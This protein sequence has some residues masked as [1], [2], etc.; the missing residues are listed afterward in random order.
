MTQTTNK[1]TETFAFTH[2]RPVSVIMPCG[3]VGTIGYDND[4]RETSITAVR[5]M[6]GTP[7]T[8]VND[9]RIA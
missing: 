9:D 1:A 6:N 4:G 2:C 7:K 3:V 8:T 5:T